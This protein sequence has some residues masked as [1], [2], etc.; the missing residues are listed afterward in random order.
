MAD[1]A[2]EL[3]SVVPVADVVLFIEAPC[4]PMADSIVGVFVDGDVV[5]RIKV[6]IYL[7]KNKDD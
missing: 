4:L 5:M 3:V 2:E 6:E 1:K 7:E